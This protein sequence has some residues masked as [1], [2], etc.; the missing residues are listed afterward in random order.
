ML[1]TTPVQYSFRM[2]IKSWEEF[3]S[4]V[5]FAWCWWKWW[6]GGDKCALGWSIGGSLWLAKQA[7]S[8]QRADPPSKP[9]ASTRA[10]GYFDRN[11]VPHTK[12]RWLESTLRLEWTPSLMLELI[13]ALCWLSSHLLE[14]YMCCLEVMLFICKHLAPFN[15]FVIEVPPPF[16]TANPAPNLAFHYK[17]AVMFWNSGSQP[18]HQAFDELDWS[19][20]GTLNL[21]IKSASPFCVWKLYWCQLQWKSCKSNHKQA[22]ERSCHKWKDCVEMLPN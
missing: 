15:D 1:V 21:N 5:K 4:P 17:T 12:W 6:W 11:V 20:N 16:H 8:L 18:Q 9:S 3:I 19:Q 7:N 14:V 22:T 10:S 2:K 13:T